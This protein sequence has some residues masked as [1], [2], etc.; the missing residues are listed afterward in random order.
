MNAFVFKGLVTNPMETV[1]ELVHQANSLWG[2]V[3][4]DPDVEDLIK[5]W[6]SVQPAIVKTGTDMRTNHHS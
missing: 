4:R 2:V 5:K 6:L 3:K 1:G